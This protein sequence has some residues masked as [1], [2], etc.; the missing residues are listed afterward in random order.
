MV[1]DLPDQSFGE[2]LWISAKLALPSVGKIVPYRTESYQQ[3][4]YVDR[5]GIWR[6]PN[7]DLEINHVLAWWRLPR[8]TL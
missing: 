5:E 7:G 1:Y 6:H 3:G 4:G 2:E 8:P